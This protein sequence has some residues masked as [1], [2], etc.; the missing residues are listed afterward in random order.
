MAS[1]AAHRPIASH[2]SLV[3]PWLRMCLWWFSPQTLLAT[4]TPKIYFCCEYI[5]RHAAD[6]M[7]TSVNGYRAE[8]MQT[9]PQLCSV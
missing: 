8:P 7:P 3:V 4:K 9:V 6:A 5:K 1:S 2:S